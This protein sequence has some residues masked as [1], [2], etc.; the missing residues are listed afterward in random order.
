MFKRYLFTAKNELIGNRSKRAYCLMAV[1]LRQSVRLGNQVKSSLR[2][3]CASQ[4]TVAELS[5][6][7][8]AGCPEP[9]GPILRTTLPGPESQR[10]MKELDQIQNAGSVQ[11]FVDYAKSQ[12]NYIADVDGNVMLDIFTQIASIPIGYNHPNLLKVMSDP[13]NLSTFINRPALAG[14][15]T[16]GLGIAP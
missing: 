4:H 16:Q 5:Q 11:F 15:S 9:Q 10:L 1:F 14:V 6:H 2:L 13:E 3:C 12:G 8:T 7:V